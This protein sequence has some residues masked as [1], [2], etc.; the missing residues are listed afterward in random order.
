MKSITVLGSTGSIGRSTLDVVRANPHKFTVR[1]LAAGRNIELLKTQIE[2]FNPAYVSTLRAEDAL[3]IEKEFQGR[4]KTGA[5]ADGAVTAASIDGADMVVSAITGAAGLI[6]TMAAIEAGKD[7][8]LANKETM[9]VAGAIV[10]EAAQK[11]GVSIL[12]VDSEHSALF[13]SLAGHRISDVRR[14]ILTAS[15]GPFFKENDID[16]DAVTPA[17]ALNHPRWSM[18][19]KVTIDSATLINKGLEVI[20]ARWLFGFSADSISV[21]I[22]PQSIVHSMVE[23][24]DGSIISQM[25]TADMRGPIAYAMGYPERINDSITPL[26]LDGLSLEFFDPD[27]ERFPCLGLAY[28]ALR[29]GGTAPAVL[30]A[31]DEVAVEDFLK[32]NIRFTDIYKVIESVLACSLSRE[33]TDIEDVLDTDNEARVKA[34]EVIKTL[35]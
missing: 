27:R 14:V 33:A 19:R 21:S 11:A 34:R 7:I 5:G 24:V 18:G 22:H 20:E 30:N 12:P 1:A 8:A 2:E 13:Q 17:Q 15:G 4:V 31:A 10:I 29:T 16:L 28:S 23:Y 9:V 3:L 26:G 32:G 25:G 35:R 6:P